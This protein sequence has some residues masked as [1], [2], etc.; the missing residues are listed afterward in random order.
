MELKQGMVLVMK[1]PDNRQMM[2]TIVAVNENTVTLDL[3]HPLA[4]KT[5]HFEVE[6]VDIAE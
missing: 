5:L 6:V 1:S 2:V 4:G 3:N